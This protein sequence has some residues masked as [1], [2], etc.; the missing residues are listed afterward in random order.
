MSSASS[1]SIISS[2]GVRVMPAVSR[3]DE[4]SS[5]R[6]PFLWVAFP[7]NGQGERVATR[8]LTYANTSDIPAAVD[9]TAEGETLKLSTQRLEVPANGEAS[10]TL[11]ID[12][13]QKAPGDYPGVVTARSGRSVI[14]T[15]AGAYVEPE[16]YNLTVTVIGRDGSPAHPYVEL[17]DPK[18]GAVHELAFQNGRG[19]VRLPVG[20][21]NLYAD[22]SERAYGKTVAH[23]AVRIAERDQQVVVDARKGKPVRVT[24]DDPSAAPERGHSLNLAHGAWGIAQSSGEDPNTRLF[25]VPARQ[26]GLRYL[27]RTIWSSKDAVPSPYMYDLAD[28]RTGGLPGDPTYTAR[29][30]DLAKVSATFRASAVPATGVPSADRASAPTGRCSSPRRPRTWTCPASSP[31]TARRASSGTAC[32]NSAPPPSAGTG[33]C[34]PRH[35]SPAASSTSGKAAVSEPRCRRS[36]ASTRCELPVRVEGAC[37]T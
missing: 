2:G 25:I 36:R 13:R 24:L 23:T 29:R 3:W 37:S 14:R 8:T 26:E 19:K 21:W 9:L 7:W 17:Y 6:P 33:T 28:H 18:T 20:E 16:S 34:S 31:T 15:P 27:L 12:A 30:K 1:A 35:P 32:S 4:S 11:T 5:R 22:F 10:L